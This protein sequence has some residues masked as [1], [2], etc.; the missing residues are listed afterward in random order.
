MTSVL[1]HQFEANRLMVIVP[2]R[3]SDLIAK[4]EM[5]P[6]YY[7]PGELFK[8]VHLVATNDDRPDLD[9]LQK[10]VG[11]AK[12]VFHNLPTGS[13]YFLR[14]L[15]WQR[16]FIEPLL[17]R[18]LDLAGRIRP[19]L[20]RTHNNFLEGVLASRIK[21]ELG[22][23]FVVSLH[24]VWDVDDR[25]TAYSIL[26]AWFRKKLERI[27]LASA[28][29]TIAVYAPI[30]RYAR[31][32]G[33]KRVELIY[34]IVAGSNISRKRTYEL[35]TP[36]RLL[37]VNRQLP[38]KNPSNIIRAVAQ[39]D[40]RYT[41]VG[42]GQLHETLQSLASELG[43]A[44]RVEFIKAI[45]NAELCARLHD[46]DLMVSHC[47]YWGTSKTVIEGALA[48]LPIVINRHP[49]IEI[50]EYRGGWIVECENTA[51]AYRTAIAGILADRPRRQFLG[52]RAF[53]TARDRFDPGQ[54]EHRTVALYRELLA[55]T[56]HRAAA[57]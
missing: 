15:G 22:I 46:F 40:C 29:A 31:A 52:E 6:R 42:D 5:T 3:L 14:S 45:P 12:I 57:E 10:A 41:I 43:C 4:G 37:T 39:I 26:R 38:Q 1:D 27:A 25:E 51:E 13:R 8:E 17:K 49:E 19:D 9:A 16:P 53:E 21:A 54:M 24:G 28:D 48:G 47:D 35:S 34:N 33:A 23:P 20:V 30:E 11:N 50:A 18:G 7:N 2:D 36:P 32:F 56:S 55:R 44:D